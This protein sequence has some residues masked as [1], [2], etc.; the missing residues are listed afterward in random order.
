MQDLAVAQLI[1]ADA[2]DILIDLIG[3]K[4][5]G[6]PENF[7]LTD[8]YRFRSITS[9]ILARWVQISSTIL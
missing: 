3:F 2:I 4:P 9:D 7:P 6:R 1:H 5:D 8:S